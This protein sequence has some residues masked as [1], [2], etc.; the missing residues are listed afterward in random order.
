MF[1]YLHVYLLKYSKK[2]RLK[3]ADGSLKWPPR[4]SFSVLCLFMS[5]LFYNKQDAEDVVNVC[6]RH[7]TT[8]FC[9]RTRGFDKE[10]SIDDKTTS[11][12]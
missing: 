6:M 3:S 11:K 1:S 2:V 12:Y 8:T 10:P 5:L 9:V 4:L 7:V